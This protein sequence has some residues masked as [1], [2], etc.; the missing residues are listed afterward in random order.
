MTTAR[1]LSTNFSPAAGPLA[2]EGLLRR[3]WPFVLAGVVARAML[4]LPNSLVTDR[5]AL[6]AA[7]A[8]TLC[9]LAAAVLIP[10]PRLPTWTQGLVPLAFLGVVALL[11]ESTGGVAGY[12]VLV[13]LP[14]LWLALY[15]NLWQLVASVVLTV[16]VF[17]VPILAIG[18]PAYPASGISRIVL[19]PLT[20]AIVG[21][22]TYRIV[23]AERARTAFVNGLLS[24]AT[25]Q[26]I[27]ATD[28][29][30]LITLFNRGAE[31][32]YGY[33]A[34]EMVGK[35]TPLAL[36]DPREVAA[37][38]AELGVPPG[39]EVFSSQARRGRAETHEW[40]YV[41]GDGERISVSMSVA[42]VY[43]SAGELRGYVKIGTDITERAAAERIKDEFVALVSHELRTPL[44]SIIGYLEVLFDEETGPLT[45]RQRQFLEVVDRNAHRQL[46]L[47]SDLLF[48]SQVDAGRV[49]LDVGDV[50]LAELAKAALEAAQP[51][52][53]AAAVALQLQADDTTTLRG[54]ADRL[55]QIFDN[56]L[57]NAIKF[58]PA[59]GSV[60]VRITGAPDTVNVQVRDTGVG[61]PVDEQGQL[62]TRFFRAS[63]ATS[64]AIPGIG[65]GLTIVKAIVDAHRG[66]VSVTSTEG[67]G[68]TF[69]INLP[70]SV[71]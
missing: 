8:S 64:R 37:R 65:L 34:D 63:T 56:L 39:F 5:P 9:L 52:A 41:R 29:D 25:E 46:R 22:S 47:V 10:W 48:V 71:Q 55:G 42:P 54:D 4:W 11:R 7:G 33:R 66:T 50:D 19:W 59:G 68:T 44:S 21:G 40:T 23:A 17:L 28:P 27:I 2:R 58:T 67:R 18:A 70:R 1:L 30:G 38:A 20:A 14:V 53:K 15:G 57:T 32:M 12:A 6:Y 60:D 62:F 3:A 51:R 36:H 26:S 13:M 45:A 31:R 43:D 16:C 69:T 49:R 24:A 61:I 35:T